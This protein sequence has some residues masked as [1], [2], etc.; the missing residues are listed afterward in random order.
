MKKYLF[1]TMTTLCM[2]IVTGWAQVFEFEFNG[3]KVDDGTIVTIPATEDE[4]GFGEWWCET[5]PSSSLYT[6]LILHLVGS[7]NVNCN[8][9]VTIERNE[10]NPATLKWC[11]GGE[12]SLMAGKTTL[13]KDF[14]ITNTGRVQVQFDAEN[15]QQEGTLMAM[16]TATIQGETHSVKI[17]FTH[18]EATS[19]QMWWGHLSGN[20]MSSSDNGLG[21]SEAGTIDVAMFV[22]KEHA[23]VGT[24]TIKAIRLWLGDD[25]SKISDD[26]RV[27]I[28]EDEPLSSGSYVQ[29]V[30]LSTLQ[31][32]KNDI[33]LTTPYEVKGKALYIGYTYTSSERSYPI[34]FEDKM[35]TKS[36][37]Y[38]HSNSGSWEDISEDY[39]CLGLQ[40]FIEGGPYP[41]NNVTVGDFGQQ[42][43]SKEQGSISVPI[44]VTNMG[45]NEITSFAYT[46]T[47]DGGSTTEEQTYDMSSYA[48]PYNETRTC[49]ITFLA[50]SKTAKYAKTLTITKLNGIK[51]K[52]AA[53][54]A[55]GS[56]IT[57]EEKPSVVPVVEEFTGT[58]CGYCPYGM[59]GMQALHE[60]YG[61]QVVL[62]AAHGSDIMTIE[63]YN[64]IRAYY[65]DGYPSS[66]I[67]RNQETYPS[68][69][70]LLNYMEKMKDAVVQGSISLSAEWG[71]TEKK[72]VN[73]TTKT[74]FV[75]SED[76]GN[77]GIAFVLVE[78]GMIGSGS[79]WAQSN[80]LS[81][82][83]VWQNDEM[84]FWKKADS[85]VTGL[86]Y[87]HVAVSA[88]DIVDGVTGSVNPHIQERDVQTF[89]YRGQIPDKNLTLIQNKSKLTA[90]ALLIDRTSGTIVNAAQAPISEMSTDITDLITNPTTIEGY[91]TIDGKRISTPAKGVNVVKY[92]DGS[93][94]KIFVK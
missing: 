1:M 46:I 12:C 71:D 40:V 49:H 51:N 28:S 30:P 86:E 4:Y 57:I 20:R 26:V 67:N 39:G 64:P 45:M 13:T 21:S 69:S 38:R 72:S 93:T 17:Q 43:V 23:F 19:E 8:A 24:S 3:Q 56:L 60:K 91:Y 85:K 50:D 55:K 11:M 81:G 75:Y 44:M 79:S 37:F 88:W 36:L 92:A 68:K 6:G 74:K 7:E 62:I 80:Y 89:T 65:V 10:L 31:V 70:N 18:G 33:E 73:F 34:M 82:S 58:W 54:E 15:I 78:D 29:S 5:N 48:I 94:K 47:T 25:L 87:D 59:V 84:E 76:E 16:L 9:T 66:I 61:D 42:V 90:I 52:S 27:W 2:S 41:K 83:S 53:K 32:G 63:D 77:Y 14:A 35:G 22:P